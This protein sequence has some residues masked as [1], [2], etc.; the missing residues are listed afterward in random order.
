MAC[1]LTLLALMVGC[2]SS[3]EA[4]PDDALGPYSSSTEDPTTPGDGETDVPTEATDLPTDACYV[5]IAISGYGTTSSELQVFNEDMSMTLLEYDFGD[6]KQLDYTIAQTYDATLGSRT[7]SE[8]D[9]DGDGT[10]DWTTQW[11]YDTDGRLT[12]MWFFDS[13]AGYDDTATYYTY[14]L[15]GRISQVQVDFGADS[16]IDEWKDYI[17][18]SS[19]ALTEVRVDAGGDGLLEERHLYSYPN[20]NPLD[21]DVDVD[22]ADDGVIEDWWKI[23]YDGSQYSGYTAWYDDIEYAI[24][25]SYSWAG[26]LLSSY[27][28]TFSYPGVEGTGFTVYTYDD[29]DRTSSE[30]SETTYFGQTSTTTEDWAWHCD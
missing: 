19:G 24:D 18:D 14:D 16:E 11:V 10:I 25:V 6:D 8:V 1:R 17:Y 4:Q 7:L 26:D 13:A 28:Y 5:D 12:E 2:A 20:I 27:D 3:P 23:R 22:L 15:D 29:Q 21:V 30:V 9:G